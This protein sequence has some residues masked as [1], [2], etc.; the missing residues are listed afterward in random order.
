MSAPSGSTS[1]NTL[2]E[3]D[4]ASC[5]E[6]ADWL[7]K[8]SAGCHDIGTGLG[9][10]RTESETIWQSEAG[11]GF[12]S[13]SGSNN[14]DA[15]TL[16]EYFNRAKIAL[17][18]FAKELDTVNAR[19]NQAREVAAQHGLTV[20]ATTIESPGPAPPKMPVEEP[21]S[22]AVERSP[23][24]EK[25]VVEYQG[26]LAAFREVNATVAEAR[27][28]ENDA[29]DALKS[30]L[31][32]TKSLP[33]AL[34]PK[35]WAWA[36]IVTGAYSGSYVMSKALDKIATD[37]RGKA[38]GAKAVLNDP[39]LSQAERQSVLRNHLEWEAKARPAATGAQAAEALDNKI[40]GGST[41]KGLAG[42][43]IKGAGVVG[44]AATGSSVVNDINKGVPADKA[45]T[46]GAA[47]TATS[48]GVGAG[49]TALAAGGYIGGVVATGG[50]LL[51]GTALAAGVGWA[52]DNYYDDVKNW[53]TS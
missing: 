19:I 34:M 32:M 46:K 3:G 17:E 45:V 52:V 24:E 23:E 20:T 39:T 43:S 12:R 29:H 9:K 6:T 44:I 47:S 41:S 26:K 37:A 7:G 36:P 10:A 30:A 25:A 4:S 11:D 13:Q 42:L 31:K 51:V 2:V 35:G 18:N 5:R 38:E 53:F 40:P 22:V 14:S 1:I 15:D 48:A 49:M 28:T 16:A 21:G 27:R 50:T 8:M 33:E